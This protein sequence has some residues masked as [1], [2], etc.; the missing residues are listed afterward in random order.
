MAVDALGIRTKITL[1]R[2]MVPRAVMGCIALVNRAARPRPPVD[3]AIQ[4]TQVIAVFMGLATIDAGIASTR[5]IAAVHH[6]NPTAV[7]VA[8]GCRVAVVLVPMLFTANPWLCYR[9]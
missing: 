3:G 8:A 4:Y 2:V 9:M 6:F 7:A 1:Y 5:H